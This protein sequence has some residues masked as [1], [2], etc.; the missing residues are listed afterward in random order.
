VSS[1]A[2]FLAK[3]RTGDYRMTFDLGAVTA[4]NRWLVWQVTASDRFLTDPLPGRQR[5]DVLLATG[6]RISFAR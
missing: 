6:F 4:I 5:N 3:G 1:R 2:R